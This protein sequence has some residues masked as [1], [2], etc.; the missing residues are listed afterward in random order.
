MFIFRSGESLTCSVGVEAEALSSQLPARGADAKCLAS[1]YLARGG[2]VLRGVWEVTCSWLYA[3]SWLGLNSLGR[4]AQASG[5]TLLLI[6]LCVSFC[7]VLY[8]GQKR[9]E[10]GRM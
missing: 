1:W 9:K 3:A 10:G 4:L 5:Q 6:S 7:L 2:G 8:I